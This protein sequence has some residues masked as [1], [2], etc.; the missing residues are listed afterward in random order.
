MSNCQE[1]VNEMQQRK[2][3]LLRLPFV[4]DTN[5]KKQ[6]WLLVM[7]TENKCAWVLPFQLRSSKPYWETS[8]FFR[9]IKLALAWLVS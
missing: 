1:E 3:V 5:K 6:S 8:G 2:L 4:V 9:L 7:E